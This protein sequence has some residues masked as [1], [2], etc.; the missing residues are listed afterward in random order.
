MKTL[1]FISLAG[2]LIPAMFLAALPGCQNEPFDVLSSHGVTGSELGLSDRF[3]VHLLH[4]DDF[5]KSLANWTT[6]IET[7]AAI[8]IVDGKLD[9]NTM[10]GST[11]WF[12][13]KLSQ[14]IAITYEVTTFDDGRDGL[15]RD[16]NLFWMALNPKDPNIR[17][18][19]AGGLGDYNCYDMYYAG[20]GG[21][22]NRTTRFR[23]YHNCNRTL[24]QESSDKTHLNA[25]N[26]TYHMRIVCLDNQVQV[27]RDGQIYWDFTD[28]SPYSEGWF[29]F[30]QTRTHL[31]ID[32]FKVYSLKAKVS[33][34]R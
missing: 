15:P 10:V 26:Q 12:N 21:N 19:G 31:Q 5:N 17:P 7:E 11:V 22:K 13:Q 30:R 6:E 18:S 20:I 1:V 34:E 4:S 3:T 23:R 24:M 2:I 25:A 9:I 29:G 32:N 14:P 28:P 27:Y 33:E 16:H 8:A